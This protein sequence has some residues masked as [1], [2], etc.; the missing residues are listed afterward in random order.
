MLAKATTRSR[1]GDAGQVGHEQI[2]EEK[3]RRNGSKWGLSRIRR[4]AMR[5]RFCA[6]GAASVRLF[7]LRR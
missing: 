5:G 1:R 7:V 4:R 3:P 2:L 6:P